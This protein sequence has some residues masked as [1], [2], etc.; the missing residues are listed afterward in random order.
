MKTVQTTVKSIDTL[1]KMCEPVMLRA[2]LFLILMLK[3]FRFINL[4][5]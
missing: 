3:L 2:T 4:E 5:K 1:L